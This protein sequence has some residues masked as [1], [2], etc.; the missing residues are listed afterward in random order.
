VSLEADWNEQAEIAAETLR[1]ETLDI[2]GPSGTPD[3][4]YRIGFPASPPVPAD[5]DFTV[6]AGTMYVGGVR[7]SLG[8][9]IT[10]RNQ[11]DLLD[12]PA[13]IPPARELVT[14]ELQEQEVSAVE[15]RALKDIALGGPDTAQRLRI[16]QRIV[17][18]PTGARDCA[19]AVEEAAKQW[20]A[21]GLT[22]GPTDL[23]LRSSARLR[24]GF[25]D[26]VPAPTPCDPAAVGGYLGAENQLIRVQVSAPNRVLWGFDNASF[27]YR[28]DVQAVDAA[29]GTS[30][31]RLHARPPD[32]FH[33]PRSG[34]TVEVLRAAA[35]LPNGAY[36]AAP[37]GI[38]AGVSAAYD[39]D[40][41]TVLLGTALPAT[42]QTP[43]NGPPVFLRVWEQEL[44]FT[45]GT[46]LTLGD[47][48]VQVTLT[49]NAA[50]APFV[51]GDYWLVAVRPS[52]PRTVYPERYLDAPQPP[53]G[54]RRWACPLGVI[55][56]TGSER[57]A[58]GTLL[59]D[60]R[61]P[62][63]NLVELTRRRTGG[64]C[65]TIVVGPD[66]VQAAG[67]LQAV[68]DAL[69]QRGP[70]T[71][72]LR[73]GA[74]R[75]ARP[76]RLSRA[77]AGLTIEG[78]PAAGAVLEAAKGTE[79]AFLDGLVVL[80]RA[81]DVSLRAL[82][83]VLPQTPFLRAG[84]IFAGIG[85]EAE[86]TKKILNEL[87]Q[88]LIVSVGV[89]AV[90]CDGV[91]IRDC[92]F[93]FPAVSPNLDHWAAGVFLGGD[94]AD[95]A[96]EGNRFAGTQ[97]VQRLNQRPFVSQFGVLAAP[98]TIVASTAGDNNRVVNIRREGH[99][100][101]A[102]L[103]STSLRRN[104]F[105]DLGAAVFAYA[106]LGKVEVA[107]NTARGC[108]G[109]FWLLNLRSLSSAALFE[110][111]GGDNNATDNSLL[112]GFAL[113]VLQDPLVFVGST[114]A[115]GYPLP[116][117]L[118]DREDYLRDDDGDDNRDRPEEDR[119][120]GGGGGGGRP[121]RGER[122]TPGP[123][124]RI[125]RELDDR[126][127]VLPRVVEIDR[128]DA[129]LDL[130]RGPATEAAPEAPPPG[131]RS[132]R[133]RAGEGTA[134]P[135]GPAD[136][137]FTAAPGV[138]APGQGLEL[139]AGLHQGLARLEQAALAKD[140][141]PGG[142]AL[143]LH[144]TGNDVDSVFVAPPRAE[145]RQPAFSSS[146]L[147]VWDD[148]RDTGSTSVISA[149]KLR[150]RNRPSVP[151]A[152]LLLVDRCSVAGNLILSEE[153]PPREAPVFVP[154]FTLVN[155]RFSLAL[156]PN[157]GIAAAP[158]VTGGPPPAPPVP[159]AITGNV[160]LGSSVLPPRPP[161]TPPT[162]PPLDTWDFLNTEL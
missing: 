72:C 33:Q 130:S 63:D 74:Y 14:L 77:H 15:D 132:R 90:R 128:N 150:G 30:R 29:A 1:E 134:P 51:V 91:V 158:P 19:G 139:F 28:V 92:D 93:V 162:P 23:R 84:G 97:N 99:F 98:K 21:Q 161:T 41:Q 27:L 103:R 45:A 144:A 62:F 2:V 105:T 7:V 157:P 16:F 40:A 107:D 54:P 100:I 50:G 87:F 96:L 47:T 116:G 155:V 129:R 141:T 5:F 36:A 66:E 127:V 89:R 121:D 126:A 64:G 133:G 113:V 48:G 102:S 32:A 49:S 138:L 73:P 140:Q 9:G 31:L 101:R 17:R 4:G 108:Y 145:Q 67:G 39:P 78:C 70:A 79:N 151:V 10:Y 8:A 83:F 65:C 69:R 122:E 68:V 13:P 112:R 117:G 80:D 95:L 86:A 85:D 18:R 146:A 152:L 142:L 52:T 110:R 75:L 6:G 136:S 34:Q 131:R 104:R 106:D 35:R 12:P 24:V 137:Q 125:G 25:S 53:D 154:A 153:T 156:V 81:E 123:I 120:G 159:V 3:D 114:V 148:P 115:R 149:N 124:R 38:V 57:A 143:A 111:G 118:D 109:G 44:T 94:C 135:V 43:E 56:W 119:D 22:F 82:R 60:C 59:A 26:T 76:L 71:V 20:L 88:N 37:T 61:N 46:A 11:P 55:G 160:F 147:L 42:H 58:T